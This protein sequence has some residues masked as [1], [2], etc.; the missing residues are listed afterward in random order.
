MHLHAE[1]ARQK[2]IPALPRPAPPHTLLWC[3]VTHL[4]FTV[5]ST[6]ARSLSNLQICTDADS[7]NDL[8]L[9]S[10]KF[11]FLPSRQ[12]WRQMKLGCIVYHMR[13]EEPILPRSSIILP[14]GYRVGSPR[15][16][17]RAAAAPSG[18]IKPAPLSLSIKMLIRAGWLAGG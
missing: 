8:N 15:L 16:D 7:K 17:R 2:K 5:I 4:T 12:V 6:F 13:K 1:L 11:H 9:F 18:G 14:S 10:S 3:R